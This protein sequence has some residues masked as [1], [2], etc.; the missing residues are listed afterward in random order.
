MSQSP[1]FPPTAVGGLIQILSTN[2]LN[3]TVIPPTAVGGLI[4]ILSTNTLNPTVIPPTAVGGYFKSPLRK[5]LNDPPTSVGGIS[6]PLGSFRVE[7]NLM[8]HPLLWV[9]FRTFEAKLCATDRFRGC[10][11]F[12]NY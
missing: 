1:K 6:R 10:F 7:S 3:P 9:G 2:I 4:Q 5:N 8:I 11:K 12:V